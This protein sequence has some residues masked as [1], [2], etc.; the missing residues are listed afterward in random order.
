MQSIAIIQTQAP[1]N[2]AKAREALDLIL[3]LAAVDYPLTVIFTGDAVY[4]LVPPAAG[5][6]T[7][8]KVFQKSFGLFAIYEIEYCLVCADSLS[9]RGLG[10]LVLPEGFTAVT[11]AEL[12]ASLDAA[13]HIIR[14]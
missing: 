2:Q 3:A 1:F 5:N 13:A 11:K 8:L 14:C 6:N 12:Q 10:Q 4:Q 9:S 7:P